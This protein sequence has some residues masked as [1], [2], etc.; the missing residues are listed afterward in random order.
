MRALAWL[1]GL[2]LL[3]LGIYFQIQVKTG[4]PEK[5][6][7]ATDD[8]GALPEAPRAVA[9]LRNAVRKGERDRWAELIAALSAVEVAQ[10]VSVLEDLSLRTMDRDMLKQI[11]QALEVGGGGQ[12]VRLLYRIGKRENDL[13][14]IAAVRLSRVHDR[15]AALDLVDVFEREEGAGPFAAAATRAL[16]QTRLRH[17]VPRLIDLGREGMDLG[18]RLAAVDGLGAIADPDALP[19]LIDLLAD[20]GAKVRR[21]AIRALSRIRS[22]RAIEALET[23][24]QGKPSPPPLEASLA[25]DSLARQRGES[26]GPWRQ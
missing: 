23:F 20:S 13:A 11:L 26:R 5:L 4:V 14:G 17:Y 21:H 2:L 3:C 18:V 9:A 16:G 22:P 1:V 19:V 12:G 24:L 6:P 8:A 15:G 7:T 10:A 25:E